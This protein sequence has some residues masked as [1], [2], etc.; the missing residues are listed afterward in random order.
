[1]LETNFKTEASN[2]VL[3]PDENIINDGKILSKI[4]KI[5]DENSIEKLNV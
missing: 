4:L 2:L 3:P 1:M 5:F